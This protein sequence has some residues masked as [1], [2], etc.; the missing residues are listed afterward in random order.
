MNA[1]VLTLFISLILVLGA[2]LLL[3]RSAGAG[4]FDHADRLSLLP[5][6]DDIVPAGKEI[7]PRPD[8]PTPIRKEDDA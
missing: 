8:S 3:G 6:E 5:L 4:D 1:L 2:I 7:A